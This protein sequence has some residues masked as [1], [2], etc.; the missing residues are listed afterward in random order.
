MKGNPTNINYKNTYPPNNNRP[1][2]DIMLSY[3]ETLKRLGKL[4]PR[5]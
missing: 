1:V 4:E 2:I 5:E 3:V